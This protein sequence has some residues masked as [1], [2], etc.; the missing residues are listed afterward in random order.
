MASRIK[1]RDQR[2]LPNSE[3]KMTAETQRDKKFPL[4]KT[5][6]KQ[7]WRDYDSATT[8]PEPRHP[9]SQRPEIR[10]NDSSSTKM[11]LQVETHP[12]WDGALRRCGVQLATHDRPTPTNTSLAPLRS[13]ASSSFKSSRDDKNVQPTGGAQPSAPSRKSTGSREAWKQVRDSTQREILNFN[14]H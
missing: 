6:R 10:S 13:A 5:R 4:L 2:G 1:S 12:G 8:P 3:R 14:G 11:Q 9:R 7:S